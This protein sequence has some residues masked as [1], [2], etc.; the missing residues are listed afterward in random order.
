MYNTIDLNKRNE[1]SDSLWDK[2]NLWKSATIAETDPLN[3]V[4][5]FI[6]QFLC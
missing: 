6:N 3:R 5:V 2:K 4:V 1:K